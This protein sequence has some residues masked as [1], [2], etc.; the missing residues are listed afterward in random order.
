[1]DWLT[2][3]LSRL[4]EVTIF[5]ILCLGGLGYLYRQERQ[6]N[7]QDRRDMITAIERQ[8]EATV[9][10]RIALSAITGKTV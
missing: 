8:A 4:N 7:R 5:F 1:M 3:I 2:P 9:Q 6:E 10:L